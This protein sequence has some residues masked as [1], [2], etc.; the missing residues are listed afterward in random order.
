VD[1]KLANGNGYTKISNVVLDLILPTLSPAAQLVYLS[2]YRQTLGWRKGRNN[3]ERKTK[4]TISQTQLMNRTGYKQRESITAAVKELLEK[5][6]INVSGEPYRSKTYT[7][8]LI[9]L[10]S[11]TCDEDSGFNKEEYEEWRTEILEIRKE[12][13]SSGK[14]D[15]Q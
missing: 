14:T 13:A 5:E 12:L 4:D 8:N 9:Q 10:F 6:L 2:I 7:I 3:P 1:K 11:Y 15:T